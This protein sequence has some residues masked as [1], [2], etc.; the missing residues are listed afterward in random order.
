M[1]IAWTSGI[2]RLRLF[3]VH[4]GLFYQ[5]SGDLSRIECDLIKDNSVFWVCFALGLLLPAAMP[6]QNPGT[7]KNRCFARWS[8]P[9]D[10]PEGV[11]FQ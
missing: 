5:D 1:M 6:Q 8:E 3:T 7:P 11:N 9:G 4:M 10:G 2:I